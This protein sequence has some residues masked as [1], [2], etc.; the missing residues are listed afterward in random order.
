MHARRTRSRVIV[1]LVG[2]V[3]AHGLLLAPPVAA[4]T[5]QVWDFYDTFSD[6][7]QQSTDDAPGGRFFYMT[8]T[9]A[10]GETG[11]DREAPYP[12]MSTFSA[13][14][15][16]PV[17]PQSLPRWHDGSDTSVGRITED[18]LNCHSHEPE[19]GHGWMHPGASS[20]AVLGWKAPSTTTIG[21]NGQLKM[22]KGCNSDG[23]NWWIDKESE[24]LA[25]GSVVDNVPARYL[26][27]M[28]GAQSLREVSVT[29]GQ[30]IYLVI[31]AGTPFDHN[32][33]GVEVDFSITS[34]AP[35]DETSVN[36]TA[37]KI[38]NRLNDGQ[39]STGDTVGDQAECTLRAAVMQSNFNPGLDNVDLAATTY[40]LTR[41]PAEEGAPDHAVGDLDILDPMSVDGGTEDA[42]D[43]VV[44]AGPTIEA[45]VDR[46]F[47]VAPR[48][49][50]EVWLRRMT[51]RHGKPVEHPQN[52]GGVRNSAPGSLTLE[53][54][55]LTDNSALCIGGGVANVHQA[56]EGDGHAS[57][58]IVRSTIEANA[59]GP[60]CPLT[61]L[62]GGVANWGGDLL[63][64][65]STLSNNESLN[66]GGGLGSVDADGGISQ[67][68]VVDST[69]SGNVGSAGA[70]IYTDTGTDGTLG[71]YNTTVTANA[72][73]SYLAATGTGLY[74][75][76]GGTITAANT[77]IGGNT[78]GD[79]VECNRA[80]TSEGHN[81]GDDTCFDGASDIIAAPQLKPLAQTFAGSTKVHVPEDDSPALDAGSTQ[82]HP[83]FSYGGPQC[84]FIDQR[85]FIRPIDGPD[86][87]T[88]ARCDIGA[89]EWTENDDTP[90]NQLPTAAFTVSCDDLTCS[91]DAAGST[92]SDGT[93][94][95]YS[96]DFGDESAAGTGVDPDHLYAA[97][98]DYTVTL[99][100]TDNAGATDTQSHTANPT[101]PSE[102]NT[103]PVA[104]DLPLAGDVITVDSGDVDVDLLEHATDADGDTVT[105]GA[106]SNV[107][108]GNILS[109]PAGVCRY[110]L[111]NPFAA[112]HSFVYSVSD[113]RGGT[114]TGKV[115]ITVKTATT[116]E[117]QV[118]Q[119]DVVPEDYTGPAHG[120]TVTEQARH[121]V[122][123]PVPVENAPHVIEYDP[124]PDWHG[125]DWFEYT[126]TVSGVLE[127]WTIYVS[128]TPVDD[129]PLAH[130][131]TIE[132]ATLNGYAVPLSGLDIDDP[133]LTFEI[134]DPP[135]G[136]TLGEI[137]APTCVALADEV[138]DNGGD[139][140]ATVNLNVASKPAQ[141][142]T[143]TYRTVD[144]NL[145][146]E[147]AQVSVDFSQP[148]SRPR[149]LT[150]TATDKA[151][152]LTWAA[153]LSAGTSPITNY[154]ARCEAGTGHSQ[155]ALVAATA[156]TKKVTGLTNGLPYECW[157]VAISADGESDPSSVITKTP[158]D[159]VAPLPLQ[160]F[161]LTP[162]L[163]RIGMEWTAPNDPD[164]HHM[165][166]RYK[167]GTTPPVNAE[168]GILV[169]GTNRLAANAGTT[170]SLTGLVVGK[171]YG[172]SAFTIDEG[173]YVRG[174][175]RVLNG[176]TLTLTGPATVVDPGTLSL[177]VTA[178]FGPANSPLA[179]QSIK[180]F[181]RNKTTGS[182]WTKI[183]QNET[184]SAGKIQWQGLKPRRHMQYKAQFAGAL[185]YMGSESDV[186]T[187]LFQP[188]AKGQLTKTTAVK[189]T[190]VKLKGTV[191][192][193]YK[194]K[195]LH[196]ERLKNGTTN[197][198]ESKEQL[199]LG[200]V[201]PATGRT[202]FVFTVTPYAATV[203]D[204]HFRVRLPA[205]TDV[206]NQAVSSKASLRVTAS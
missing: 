48:R 201:D 33:D 136:V 177:T 192:P 60:E 178:T 90:V 119:A 182:E 51:I 18:G 111:S 67:A 96:W 71:L 15:D 194:G 151:V 191:S 78:G 21:I 160:N 173:G 132:D 92:D 20:L 170:A 72:A 62:G 126:A 7:A 79:G 31:D 40:T 61:G 105:F 34:V 149:Q 128:V 66:A 2:A 148:P 203:G 85:A 199:V 4:T 158:V 154:R 75:Q 63:I 115:T 95:T 38:D 94:S 104:P 123:T 127:R 139:C 184:A 46:V 164:L 1:L 146:S 50:E 103:P 8:D 44:Q 144:G 107:Q 187:V 138:N 169:P 29:A 206:H 159:N 82:V 97:E 147:T 131:V 74:G 189:G 137:S 73:S 108:G 133:T 37:D 140:D 142:I 167:E 121:G 193:Y 162:G 9:L 124:D 106:V 83:I 114:D 89:V 39:C 42:D 81:L 64:R 113:G 168:D 175:K 56:A 157:V 76:P 26:S 195:T 68:N 24:N 156:L 23:V 52:G 57:L 181:A 45:A 153:P 129:A 112:E 109:C 17:G 32:C 116:L 174:V 59:A 102:E 65:E 163:R 25:S 54:V 150:G 205:T 185:P 188:T 198:W 41:G 100:V 161:T 179:Y 69:I 186:K 172:I 197:T 118:L 99:T 101:A 152:E 120:A 122:A 35:V 77:I 84:T 16:C 200:N 155:E 80:V 10:E 202:P 86:V 166:I 28:E 14:V 22:T 135:V 5:P 3:V 58:T 110:G 49:A 176:V 88:T 125:I 87:D 141:P 143:F 30:L 6:A 117:D 27:Q 36:S 12:L 180:L 165:M 70:G 98:D 43:T 55:V 171:S 19:P 130:D 11:A 13:E 93:I 91:F 47:D 53:T 204:H 145:D 183:R 190:V 134:V 196:L